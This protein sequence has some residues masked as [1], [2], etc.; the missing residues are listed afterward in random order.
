[1]WPLNEDLPIFQTL[2]YG[3]MWRVRGFLARG[4]APSDP[5]MATAAVELGESFQRQGPISAALIRWAPFAA[6]VGLGA[7][8][9]FAAINGNL[10]QAALYG[11]IALANIAHIIFN[12][13]TRPRNVVRSLE[14]SRRVVASGR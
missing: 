6:A 12:P 1:M 8:S 5:R 9:A 4:E 13:A 14:G 3:D 11:L 2:S 10:L 7:A